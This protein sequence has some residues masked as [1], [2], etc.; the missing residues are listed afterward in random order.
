MTGAPRRRRK[1]TFEEQERAQVAD[2]DHGLPEPVGHALLGF[3]S[4]AH[5]PPR[6]RGVPGSTEST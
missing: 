3:G 5:D 6:G 2:V 1:Q 4:P